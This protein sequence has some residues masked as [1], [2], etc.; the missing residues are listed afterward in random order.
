MEITDFYFLQLHGS[1]STPLTPK[2][3]L[4]CTDY[5]QNMTLHALLNT[6]KNPKTTGS[7]N[8]FTASLCKFLSIYSIF[9]ENGTFTWV[10][11]SRIPHFYRKF[12]NNL[13]LD[14]TSE[15]I[16]IYEKGSIYE[17]SSIITTFSLCLFGFFLMCVCSL[18]CDTE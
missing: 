15:I 5:V 2:L 16:K 12:L 10:N 17:K 18:G 6:E 13:T 1:K 3:P 4:R 9:E 8:F 7:S 14:L 11:A